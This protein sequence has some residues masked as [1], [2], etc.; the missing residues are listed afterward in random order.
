METINNKVWPPIARDLGQ[1]LK[2]TRMNKEKKG[3]ERG[4]RQIT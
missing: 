3:F 1:I 2:S 4:E